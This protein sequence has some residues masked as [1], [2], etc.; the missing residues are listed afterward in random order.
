MEPGSAIVVTASLAGLEPMASDPVYALTKHALV[1][2]VRS[3][4]RQLADR[5]VRIVAVDPGIAD[6][7]LLGGAGERLRQAGFPLLRADEVARAVLLAARGGGTGE[8][9]PVHPGREPE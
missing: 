5:G 2:F 9:W 4:A 1:G 6:T 3:V 7:P 8:V